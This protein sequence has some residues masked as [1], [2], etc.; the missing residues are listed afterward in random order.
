MLRRY[1]HEFP[2]DAGTNIHIIFSPVVDKL[3]NIDLVESGKEDTDAIIQS[4]APYCD[5]NII[6]ANAMQG[7]LS[8]LNRVRGT[9]GDF[10]DMPKTYAEF[11]QLQIDSNKMFEKLPPDIKKQFDNDPNKFMVDAGS[12]EWLNKLGIVKEESS[13]IKDTS[14]VKSDG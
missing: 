2:S 13:D 14:E 3:G 9:F 11:L 5:I 10:T 4:Y 7:D 6:M 1:N 12:E 8:G